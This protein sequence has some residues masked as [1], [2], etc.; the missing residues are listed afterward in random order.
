MFRTPLSRSV[1]GSVTPFALVAKTLAT[2]K[3]MRSEVSGVAASTI[4]CRIS[5]SETTT[6]LDGDEDAVPH[7]RQRAAHQQRRRR[8]RGQ[9]G[10][11]VRSMAGMDAWDGTFVSAP[12]PARPNRMHLA[13]AAGRRGMG[14][15]ERA[16]S[17]ADCAA[18]PA[19]GGRQTPVRLRRL[20][21]LPPPREVRLA[22]ERRH[23]RLEALPDLPV[24]ADLLAVLPDA[25]RE[26]GQERR[27]E[28]GRLDEARPLHRNAEQVRLELHEQ[29]VL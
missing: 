26:P 16:G 23:P 21:R 1:P 13:R 10:T 11:R 17:G 7:P 29:V 19:A 24:P 8:A 27:A 15:R 28:R 14:Q 25:R 22:L 2:S 20:E 6:R 5:A 18:R 3:P 9:E 12:F 4:A